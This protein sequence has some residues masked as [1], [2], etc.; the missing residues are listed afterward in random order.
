MAQHWL[1]VVLRVV[2][3]WT[4]GNPAGFAGVTG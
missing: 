4:V 1:S 2:R 3:M